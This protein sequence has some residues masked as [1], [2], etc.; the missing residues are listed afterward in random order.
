MSDDDL[1]RIYRQKLRPPPAPRLGE[2][3]VARG[4]IDRRQLF[5]ALT[6]QARHRCRIGDALVWLGHLERGNLELAAASRTPSRGLSGDDTVVRSM[7]RGTPPL[8]S[9]RPPADLDATRMLRP[10]GGQ[11]DD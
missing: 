8:P 2:F 9:A 6:V 3:L 7:P 11:R 5:E 10:R 1:T 4:L